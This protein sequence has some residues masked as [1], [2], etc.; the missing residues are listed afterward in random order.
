M[1]Y[2]PLDTTA[3][4]AANVRGTDL[5]AIRNNGLAL[6][7]GILMGRIAGFTLSTAS[8][9]EE[10]A[11]RKWVNASN[12][13]V[14]AT[15]TYS[16]GY[17][18]QVVWDYAP[19]NATWSTI[20]TET[21]TYTSTHQTGGANSSLLSWLYEWIGKLKDLRTLYTAHAAAT[22][23]SAHGLGT[24]STQA[25]SAVAITG[26]AFNGTVG[27]TTP[28]D[29][30]FTRACEQFNTYTP[31]SGRQSGAGLDE[32]RIEPDQQRQQHGVVQQR[33]GVAGGDARA[34][35]HGIQQHDLPGRRDL[36]AGRQAVHRRQ[37]G[38]LARH[39][40]RR[41]HGIRRHHVA[42][43]LMLKVVSCRSSVVAVSIT[44][45]GAKNIHTL[46][47][48][49]ASAVAVAVT[50]ASGVVVAG[51]VSGSLPAGSTIYLVNAGRIE[52]SGGN[53]RGTGVGSVG[54]D[55]ISSSVNITIDNASG[56]I[57][58]GGGGGGRGGGPVGTGL[59]EAGYGGGGGGRGN[60]GGT[61]GTGYNTSSGADG[62]NG[63]NGSRTAYGAGGA[64]GNNS[65]YDTYGGSGGR[66]GTWGEAGTT[67][68]ISSTGGAGTA[69]YAAGY[70]VKTTGGATVTFVAGN[71]S[72][73]VRGSVG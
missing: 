27:A 71:N 58:G 54:G 3:P 17:V 70:A 48:S 43:K 2:T 29:G 15:Y 13:A 45:D 62:S 26:G 14:R 60:A 41:H 11:W 34:L 52:G 72:T 53:G 42:G 69:G 10:P 22:G 49:P 47:G 30:L 16:S 4:N 8:N 21:C 44:T 66:G 63:S 40:R 28:A 57:L 38:R 24:M 68:D 31:G 20:A 46:A 6:R 67:G 36:G 51:M 7:D 32:G 73:Q 19:D 64:G 56:Y 23:T 61:G 39:L 1:A 18:T 55:A 9:V 50:V 12:N 37:G 25:A 59:G 35:L 33:A 65:F 5:T